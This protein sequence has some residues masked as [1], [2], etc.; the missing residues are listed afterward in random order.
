MPTSFQIPKG[1]VWAGNFFK[2]HR[3]DVSGLTT[4]S[5]WSWDF[6]LDMSDC[7][8]GTTIKLCGVSTA[9][10]FRFNRVKLGG[11]EQLFSFTHEDSDRF[12]AT[13]SGNQIVLKTYV[14]R[15]GYGPA[16]TMEKAP[17]RRFSEKA[18][19]VENGARFTLRVEYTEGCADCG[20][21]SKPRGTDFHV[22]QPNL[23]VQTVFHRR[24]RKPSFLK[25]KTFAHAKGY[26]QPVAPGNINI[27]LF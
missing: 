9:S 3:S 16:T 24:V 23:P 15:Q 14:Y 17:V 26:K 8:D 7:P 20:S 5:S 13:K 1:D 21:N 4:G 2:R 11:W 19:T 6:K 22:E 10:P 12:L 18:A 25:H 27:T